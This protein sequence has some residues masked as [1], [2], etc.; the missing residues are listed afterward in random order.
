[1]TVKTNFGKLTLCSNKEKVGSVFYLLIALHNK[2]GREKLEL[3]HEWQRDKYC[4]FP[5]KMAIASMNLATKKK[6]SK[7]EAPSYW[8]DQR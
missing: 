3:A 2:R 7:T 1:M 8:R 6:S 5:N 4:A